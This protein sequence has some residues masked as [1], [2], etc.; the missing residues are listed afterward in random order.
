MTPFVF[1]LEIIILHFIIIDETPKD[2]LTTDNE[3]FDFGL[4]LLEQRLLRVRHPIDF[5]LEVRKKLAEHPPPTS[6]LDEAVLGEDLDRS[7]G[8]VRPLA[9]PLPIF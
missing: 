3:F 6:V 5:S 1:C 2:F 4:N 8:D 9:A 7:E